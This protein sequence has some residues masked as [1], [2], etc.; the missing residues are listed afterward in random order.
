ME[1]APRLVLQLD[2]ALNPVQ[3]GESH[4][5]YCMQRGRFSSPVFVWFLTSFNNLC[6]VLNSSIN[7]VIYCLAGRTFR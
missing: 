3:L 6:L 2:A 5:R 1:R 4:F 7:F